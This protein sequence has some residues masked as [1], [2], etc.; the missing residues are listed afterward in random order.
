MAIC[1]EPVKKAGCFAA[2]ACAKRDLCPIALQAAWSQSQHPDPAQWTMTDTGITVAPQSA[3]VQARLEA[4]A[5]LLGSDRLGKGPLD[6]RVLSAD[7]AEVWESELWN[8]VL[9]QRSA[10]ADAVLAEA[11]A[12]FA[13]AETATAE[14]DFDR[15]ASKAM[16]AYH[17]IGA[18]NTLLAG[19]QF[20]APAERFEALREQITKGK[21]ADIA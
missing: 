20:D 14:D 19:D 3:L 4:T 7:R 2:L 12:A 11:D 6:K 21:R 1:R 5:A 16:Y 18:N 13:A 9:A 15:A 10:A 17:L 8:Q